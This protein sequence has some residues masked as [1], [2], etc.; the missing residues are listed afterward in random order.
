M[1]ESANIEDKA[2]SPT[3]EQMSGVDDL[4]VSQNSCPM[5]SRAQHRMKNPHSI[6]QD[7]HA[8]TIVVS[9]NDDVVV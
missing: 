1:S 5:R 6:S 7:T 8:S 9:L 3:E 2:R 4:R